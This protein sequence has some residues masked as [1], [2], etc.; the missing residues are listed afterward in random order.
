MYP[1]AAGKAIIIVACAEMRVGVDLLVT[2]FLLDITCTGQMPPFA[3][4]EICLV[5]VIFN[6]E[7][8]E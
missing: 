1:A 2:N 6:R 7:T 3:S 8:L 4:W 5:P